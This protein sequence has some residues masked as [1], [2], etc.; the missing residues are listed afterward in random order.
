MANIDTLRN[1]T[2]LTPAVNN[3]S[4]NAAIFYVDFADLTWTGATDVIRFGTLPKG[5]IIHAAIV[6]QLVAGTGSGTLTLSIN[7]IDTSA[8]LAST[9]AAGTIEAVADVSGGAPFVLTADGE[10]ALTSATATRTDGSMRVIV[11]YSQLP[12]ARPDEVSRDALA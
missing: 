4:T 12:P 2:N 6:E 11:Y 5:S 3:V 9:D 7:S 10:V 8:A 1:T